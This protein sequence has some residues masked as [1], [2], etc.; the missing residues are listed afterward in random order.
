MKKTELETALAA[1]KHIRVAMATTCSA[2]T[3][4][5]R[6]LTALFTDSSDDIHFIVSASSD[7]CQSLAQEPSLHLSF[8]DIKEQDYLSVTTN[9]SVTSDAALAKSLW[10]PFVQVWFPIGPTD[11][12]VRVITARTD[13]IEHWAGESRKLVLAWEM[14]KSLLTNERPDLGKKLSISL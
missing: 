14:A 5:S 12:D 6:P 7:I 8:A 1:I 13:H 4:R 3:M 10:S 9:A 2:G 11:P